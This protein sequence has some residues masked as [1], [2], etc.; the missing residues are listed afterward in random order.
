[1]IG[2]FFDEVA[3][4]QRVELGQY[5]FTD[6]NITAYSSAFAPVA[7][8]LDENAA[9][10]GLFGR[11][12]AAGFHIGSAWMACFVAKNTEARK[13]REA[14]GQALPDIGPS[15][16]L[17]RIVWPAPVFAGDIISCCIETTDKRVSRSHPQWGLV[18]SHNTGHNQTGTKVLEF[19]S[20]VLV[21]I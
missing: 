6:E 18:T 3:I 1:M 9:A 21:W 19:H 11:K 15:P 5:K 13:A 12:C 4:G 20:T 8:Q 2:L 17:E 10:H 16:G 7:F 14:L